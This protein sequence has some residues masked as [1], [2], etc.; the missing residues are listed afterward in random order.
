MITTRIGSLKLDDLKV[1]DGEPRVFYNK[2]M[3][4]EDGKQ[5][6]GEW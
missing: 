6:K 2:M 1:E 3:D 4:V 5:Y